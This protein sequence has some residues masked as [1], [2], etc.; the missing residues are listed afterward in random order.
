MLLYEAGINFAERQR[1]NP[2]QDWTYLCQMFARQCVGAGAWSGSALGAWN[3]IPEKNKHRTTTPRAGSLLYFGKNYPG[4][5]VYVVDNGYCYSN[6]ILQRGKIS[7]VPWTL[8]TEKW[9]SDYPKLGWIDWTPSGPIN[10]KP[11][12]VDN[13][14]I[15]DLSMLQTAAKRDPSK[16]AG[17]YTYRTG[18]LVVERAMVKAGYLSTAYDDG[19]FGTRTRSAYVKVQKRFKVPFDDGIPRLTDLT[20]LGKVYNFKVTP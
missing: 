14:P 12:V 9:G 6:D 19:H 3:A 7:K 18:T 8:I 17:T 10:L 20:A 5:V 13:R 15:V 2:T 4:H 11:I 1:T 16:P